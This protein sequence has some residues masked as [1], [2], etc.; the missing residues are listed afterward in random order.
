MLGLAWLGFGKPVPQRTRMASFR[1]H[2]PMAKSGSECQ[3]NSKETLNRSQGM[4]RLGSMISVIPNNYHTAR[5]EQMSVRRC[6]CQVEIKQPWWPLYHSYSGL[7]AGCSLESHA[8]RSTVQAASRSVQSSLLLR[9]CI[10]FDKQ[11][12]RRP[13]PTREDQLDELPSLKSCWLAT[14]LDFLCDRTIRC[15]VR[16]LQYC[17]QPQD[18]P[19]KRQ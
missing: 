15:L 9:S 1:P 3:R 8:S 5:R 12:A 16:W 17:M 19:R 4:V 6:V 18:Q 14:C 7:D 2:Q 13:H 10:S 11:F